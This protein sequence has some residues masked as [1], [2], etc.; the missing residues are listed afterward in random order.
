MVNQQYLHLY[1]RYDHFANILTKILDEQPTNTV[2]IIENISKDV[3]CAQFRK[4]MDTLRDEPL[5]RPTFEAAEKCK[6]LFRKEGREEE[7]E[8]PEEEMVSYYRSETGTKYT[9]AGWADGGQGKEKGR[10]CGLFCSAASRDHTNNCNHS[11]LYPLH[12]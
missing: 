11:T 9:R 8:E 4:K 3:K 1:D 12:S 2:D 6:V 5:I 7:R 10:K